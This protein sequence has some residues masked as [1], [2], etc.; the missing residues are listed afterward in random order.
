MKKIISVILVSAMELSLA[1][2]S[3]KPGNTKRPDRD[4]KDTMAYKPEGPD[5]VFIDETTV[6]TSESSETT[7]A[8]TEAATEATT[9]TTEALPKASDFVVDARAD[10]RHLEIEGEYHVPRV[11]FSSPDVTEMQQ[12]IDGCFA[13]YAE[14]IAEYGYCHYSRTDY[15]AYLTPNGVLSI[16]FVERGEWDDDIYHVWNFDTAFGNKLENYKTASVAEVY[17]ISKAARDALQTYYNKTGYMVV[18]DYELVSS[19]FDYI[20]EAVAMSFSDEMINDDMLIG[21][22]D[23]GSLFFISPVA[24]IAGAEYYYRMYDA[25]GNDIS[26]DAGWVR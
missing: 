12:E 11:L 14:D 22:R 21:L 8:T 17:D 4:T 10:Y 6:Q 26:Y 9:T 3:S 13:V 2:C 18:E 15:A 23:D 7:A 20:E 19:D 16:V 1:A 24:S 5:P 25:D